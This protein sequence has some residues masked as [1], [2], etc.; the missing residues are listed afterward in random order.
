[1]IG[2]DQHCGMQ[3]ALVQFAHDSGRDLVQQLDEFQMA[4]MGYNPMN[5]TVRS[6]YR[7]IE[8]QLHLNQTPGE[9]TSHMIE[10]DM[11]MACL[12]YG[13]QRRWIFAQGGAA[14]EAMLADDLQR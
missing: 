14:L 9:D 4:S 12:A 8:D 3:M 11:M 13:I 10:E 5:P 2:D 6:L 1:L 7:S